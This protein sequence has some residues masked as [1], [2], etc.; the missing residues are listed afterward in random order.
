MS[1]GAVV[2]SEKE[3]AM[4]RADA[5]CAIR[6]SATVFFLLAMLAA[7]PGA[8]HAGDAV[9][10]R[11]LIYVT[12]DE[13][14][15]RINVHG[16]TGSVR[17][18]AFTPDSARLCSGGWDKV[19]QV[20]NLRAVTRDLQGVF[21]RE[22]TI[23]WQVARGPLG[24]IHA[25]AI[26]PNDGLLALAGHS[27]MGSLGEI[28]L[29]DPVQGTLDR[30]L[31]GHRQ[32]VC[33]L[34][35][36]AD[37]QWLVSNDVQGQAIVWNRRDWKPNVLYQ[38]DENTYGVERARRIRQEPNFRPLAIVGNTHVVLPVH[39]G[40]EPDGRL[41]WNL[42][43]IRLGNPA[44]VATWPTVHHRMVSALAASRDGKRLV[45]ADLEGKLFLWD[46]GAAKA[47][48]LDAGAPVLSAAFSPDGRTLAIG[49]A[50]RAGSGTAEFQLWDVASATVRRRQASADHVSACAVSPDGKHAAYTGGKDF[51]VFVES[52]AGDRPRITLGGKGRRVLKVAFAKEQP[53]YRVAFGSRLNERGFNDYGDLE[54]TF[55]AQR[56]ELGRDEPLAPGDWLTGETYAGP[57]KAAWQDG[58]LQLFRDGQPKGR[59]VLRTALGE[60]AIRAYCWI[61]DRQGNPA[62]IAVG[63]DVQNSI[64][65]CRLTEQGDCPVL[66]HF[67]GHNDSVLSLAVSRDLRYLVSGSADGTLCFWSL[68]DHESGAAPYSR[69]GAEFDLKAD[70]PGGERRLVVRRIH[71]A[72]PLYH[73]GV[74]EGDAIATIRW[75]ADRD[76]QKKLE[77]T[78]PDE[79]LEHL[80]DMPWGTL[81]EFRTLREGSARPGFQLRPAWQA[82]A[83]LFVSAD[84][85]WAFW[86]PEGYFDASINGHTLFGWQVNRGVDVLPA[87]YRADHFRQKLEQPSVLEELLPAGNLPEA[88]TRAKI[89]PIGELPRAV[90]DQIA[91]APAMEILQPES[92]AEVAGNVARVRARVQVPLQNELV[93]AKIY[94]SGVVGRERKLV[95]QRK[96]EHYVEHTYEWLVSLPSEETNLI[97]VVVGT[98]AEVTA[99]ND[100]VIRRVNLVRP[101]RPKMYVVAVGI[102]KYADPKVPPL[103]FSAA[104]AE[105]FRNVLRTR[106]QGLYDVVAATLLLNEDVTPQKWRQTLEELRR[107]LKDRVG[108]DDLLVLFLAGHGWEDVRTR[109]YYFIGH[110]FRMANLGKSYEGCIAW[111]DFRLLGD[112]PC[113]KLAFLDTCHSGAIQP[114]RSR[115]MKAAVRRLQDDVIF[116]VTASK[117]GQLAAEHPEWKH[118][119]FTKCLVDALEGKAVQTDRGEVTLN[120]VVKYVETTVP[121]VTSELTQGAKTQEPTAAPDGLLAYARI[122]LVRAGAGQTGTGRPP[123]TWTPVALGARP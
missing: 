57:W 41:I 123:A 71:P 55:D 20:W 31:D 70:G 10:T 5:A 33:A 77:A 92:D 82:V 62:A 109:Q 102:N 65:V 107:T 90:P 52:L 42:Q 27:A 7:S 72:G 74:R 112:I 119:V 64:Y 111:D 104:D 17:A 81:V 115:N 32:A 94:A 1:N 26:A 21:L 19:V 60:G 117:G 118:G 99:S 25:L 100:L 39:V 44:E 24:Q 38:P 80:R 11:D 35:F 110:E 9:R 36:S 8:G 3:Q 84:R 51:E 88:F 86:T 95:A 98:Q 93:E 49:T 28:L 46:L 69:W 45:S 16:H 91:Q 4:R 116:T 43:S 63:T 101:Q 106:A 2:F 50:L 89:K 14:H 37:G 18:L 59:V 40:Q 23:R 85:E 6:G 96:A 97:Q 73:K 54:R 105:A 15:L 48:P 66:R 87:Y 120:D 34:A 122:P 12:S 108:P 58:G 22:R 68:A 121:R 13:P 76:G 78:R 29:I 114:P 79:I 83:T 56:L 113:R 67:R 75:Y 30:V 53:Y 47:Q 103:E 61:P